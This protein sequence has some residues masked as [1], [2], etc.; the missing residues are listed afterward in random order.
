MRVLGMSV[1]GGITALFCCALQAGDRPFLLADTAIQEDDDERVFEVSTWAQKASRFKSLQAEVEY[2]FVPDFS[3]EFGWGRK[4]VRG[5]DEPEAETELEF[6]VRKVLRDPARH[7]WGVGLTAEVGAS[8]EVE[9]DERTGWRYGESRIAVP[10]SRQWGPVWTHLTLGAQHER[11]EG[12]RPLA[13]LAVL[14]SVSRSAKLFAEWGAV[15]DRSGLAQAG[16]RWWIQRERVA[17]ELAAVRH[18]EGGERHNA[19]LLGLSVMDLSW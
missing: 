8:R 5:E 19:V 18:R 12:V 3:I 10:L 14:G 17:V 11:R 16:V 6:G 4:L 13:A 15:R 1:V 9:G 2:S 7:G